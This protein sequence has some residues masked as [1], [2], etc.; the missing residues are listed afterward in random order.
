MKEKLWS[1]NQRGVTIK[2]IGTRTG[3]SNSSRDKKRSALSPGKRISASGNTYY[4]KRK[5]R[6]DLKNKI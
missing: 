2:E 1:M 3:K 4:E 5:N 6:S